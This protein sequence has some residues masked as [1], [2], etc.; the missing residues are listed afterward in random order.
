MIA[1]LDIPLGIPPGVS[2]GIFRNSFKNFL[3]SSSKN[4]PEVPVAAYFRRSLR[5]T[6]RVPLRNPSVVS[7]E[8]S[9]G[10]LF[11]IPAAVLDG[12]FQEFNRGYL[13]VILPNF[14][15]SSFSNFSRSLFKKSPG[16][17]VRTHP[18]D[19][20]EVFFRILIKKSFRSS[21]G[22]LLQEFLHIFSGLYPFV[23]YSWILSLGISSGFFSQEIHYKFI[24]KF[25]R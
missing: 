18:G 7:S 5:N 11:G 12:F 1:S 24:I 15:R 17:P 3:T 6:P 14:F 23:N 16:L 25:F 10:N 4:F 2:L 20:L 9:L 19:H 22:D 13:Q 8:I 21:I